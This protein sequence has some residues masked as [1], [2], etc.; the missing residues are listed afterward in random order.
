MTTE[1]EVKI[2]R[3]EMVMMRLICGFTLR[4]RKKEMCRAQRIVGLEPA[5]SLVM[6]NDRWR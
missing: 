4:E 2:D 5:G 6:K 3:N 1:R